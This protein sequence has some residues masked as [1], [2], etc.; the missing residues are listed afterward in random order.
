MELAERRETFLLL[1]PLSV[2]QINLKDCYLV[3]AHLGPFEWEV[4]AL[5]TANVE[6]IGKGLPPVHCILHF[7]AMRNLR[8]LTAETK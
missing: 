4:V 2:I 8:L 7:D 5:D 1:T 6:K 3:L